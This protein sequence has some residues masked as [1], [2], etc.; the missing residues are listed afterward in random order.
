MSYLGKEEQIQQEPVLHQFV[1]IAQNDSLIQ[2]D[3]IRNLAGVTDVI[4]ESPAQLE[5]QIHQLSIHVDDV[6]TKSMTQKFQGIRLV[7][8]AKISAEE[9]QAVR[10][11]FI[12]GYGE[13][14]VS[15]SPIEE[16]QKISIPAPILL[17]LK[18]QGFWA[19]FFLAMGGWFFS[20]KVLLV[21]FKSYFI[22]L[23]SINRIRY[24]MFKSFLSLL[25]PLW[26]FTLLFVLFYKEQF[27]LEFF[28]PT[29]LFLL[30]LL[31]SLKK[32]LVL[33]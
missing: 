4:L 23:Q 27:P 24:V 9:I 18:T 33:L 11:Y 29:G 13:A 2:I 32:D 25:L 6:F 31:F 28:L 16:V 5:N 30:L 14:Q 7:L 1:L 19:I 10:N 21:P 26:I 17:K 20:L 22:F 8:D 3:K 12:T 15:F